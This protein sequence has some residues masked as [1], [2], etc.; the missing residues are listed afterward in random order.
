MYA[1]EWTGENGIFRLTINGKIQKEIRPVF[2][3][4]LDY[5]GLN[6]VWTY[7]DTE[8]PLLWAEGIRRYILNGKLVAEAKGGGFYSKPKI[9]IYDDTL[10]L[11]PI[12]V[13]KLWSENKD[14]MSGLERTAVDFIRHTHDEYKEKG[15]T[16]AV[17]FSG[18]KDSLVLLDLVSRALSPDEFY[19]V[20]SNTG[21]ELSC[22]LNSVEA[23]KKHWPMLRF[24]EA[25]SHLNPLDSWKEFGP[26]GR[27]MRWCCSVHKS[28]PTILKLRELTENYNV[29]AVVFDGVRAEESAQRATYEEISV[30][31]K[32]INQI[33]CSPILKWNTAE[34]YLYLLRNNILF[35]KAYRQ[36]LFRVGCMVCP[37]SSAWWDGI[38]NDIYKAVLKPDAS[39]QSVM[40]VTKIVMCL[41]GV[42]SM[43]IALFNTQSIVS[44]LMFCFTL[45]AAGSFFPYVMGHYW[46]KASKAGTIA[47][48]IAGTV[49][50][51]YLEHISGG[52][53]FGIKFS[54]PIIPG[55]VA[56]FI[57]FIAFSMIMPPKEETTELASEE[58]D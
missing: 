15:Y 25:K 1:Y 16:F 31:A 7:P 32:N 51:V 36:G 49:V 37:M 29:Q 2:K 22:T 18:G 54:Q 50:V 21:M 44:I 55:L 26:P 20:F 14:I 42:A 34:L 4:E 46:K 30:G 27:R 48:L 39:S 45:R 43:F 5:F 3:E 11:D 40:K 8:F 28:V 35:N 47:S 56:A 52:V 17:G 24:Y 9:K 23:A 19:V 58:D 53:L 57:G 33:N 12:D 10:N 6:E 38:A 41:V 13:S